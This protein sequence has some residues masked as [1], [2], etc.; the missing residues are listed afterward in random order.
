MNIEDLRLYCLGKKG[1]TE[2]FPFDEETLVFK[3]LDKMFLL[4]NINGDLRMNVKCDPEKA[5]D[6]REK[7]PTVLPG[8]HMNK[9]LWNTIVLNGEISDNLIKQWIDDSYNLI[10]ANLPRRKQA[11]L[12]ND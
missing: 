1:V 10:V 4:T 8:Y 7:Y 3:V 5:I 6:L 11:E 2:G 12:K 9:R